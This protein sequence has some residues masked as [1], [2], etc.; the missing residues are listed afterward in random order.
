MPR[1][2]RRRVQPLPRSTRVADSANLRAVI[3]LPLVLR[4]VRLAFVF[5]IV[6]SFAIFV[7]PTRYRYDHVVTEGDTY[8]VRID[9]FNGD[10]DMLTPDDG[11]YPMGDTDSTGDSPDA[12]T[13]GTHRGRPRATS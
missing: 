8:P 4:F 7:W 5:A 9:R 3:T 6:L 11:W 12:H 13:S 2:D 1:T 10:S